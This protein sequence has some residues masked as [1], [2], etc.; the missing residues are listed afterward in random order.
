MSTFKKGNTQQVEN[1][2][3]QVFNNFCKAGEK[4]VYVDPN[5]DASGN[6]SKPA[7]YVCLGGLKDTSGTLISCGMKDE[8]EFLIDRSEIHIPCYTIYDYKKNTD[9][10]YTVCAWNKEAAHIGW[11]HFVEMPSYNDYFAN[12]NI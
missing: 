7:V 12:I 11:R 2:Q 8:N 6:R 4:C 5:Q 1:T 3:V 9:N 10:K